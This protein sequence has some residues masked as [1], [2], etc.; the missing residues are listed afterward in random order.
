MDDSRIL[1]HLDA[2][3]KLGIWEMDVSITF[4]FFIF[5]GFMKGT[6]TGFFGAAAVG[7]FASSRIAKLKAMRHTGYLWHFLYWWLPQ[8]LMLLIPRGVIPPSHYRELAG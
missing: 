7:Y 4:I 5:L 1:R 6:M 2:P 8:E 3:W